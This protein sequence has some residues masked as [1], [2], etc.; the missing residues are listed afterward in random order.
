MD[1]YTR[2]S[3]FREAGLWV[4]A[5]PVLAPVYF[6][7]ATAF[8]T[9][10]DAA[11]S[12][13]APPAPPTPG[14][15]TRAWAEAGGESVSFGQ[16]LLNSVVTTAAVVALL[17]A[18]AAPAGYVLARRASRVSGLLFGLFTLGMILPV[19]LGL[20]PLYAVMVETGLA[21]TRGGLVLVYLGLQMPLA[22]FLYAGFFRGLPAAYEEAA[23]VDGAAPVRIFVQI[24]FPLVRP[25]T[26][27]VAVLTG[28]FVWNDFFVALVFVGDTG[29]V[30]LPVAVYS[31]VGR[32][33]AEWPLIFAAALIALAPV[34]LV[35]GFMQRS[36]TRGFVSALRG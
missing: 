31:F 28:L 14:N 22:V 11:G 9:P 8:K 29:K 23:R 35:Y 7:A 15:L 24:V 32:F 19:Q 6:V 27:V 25:V 33:S 21:G 5:I 16:A 2:W 26:G 4:A 10:A 3:A 13:F 1:R 34:L 36:I 20:I 18:I 12:P 30:T 17:V